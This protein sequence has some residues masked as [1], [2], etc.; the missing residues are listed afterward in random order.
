MVSSLAFLMRFF[1]FEIVFSLKF[2]HIFLPKLDKTYN[3][4]MIINTLSDF[5]NIG[6]SHMRVKQLGYDGNCFPKDMEAFANFLDSEQT[7]KC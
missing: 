2:I 3:W 1:Y 4:H 5:E 6:P 7:P